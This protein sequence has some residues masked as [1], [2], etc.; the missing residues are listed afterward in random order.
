MGFSNISEEEI[1][2]MLE[3][4]ARDSSVV[5]KAKFVPLQEVDTEDAEHDIGFLGDINVELT[6]ELGETTKTVRE[7]LELEK[8]SV[9]PI[10]RLAGEHADIIINGVP[11]AS[12]E[13]VVINEVLGVRINTLIDPE[14]YNE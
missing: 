6:V 1:K 8:G 2:S 13:V 11:F 10:N 9:F 5:K 14:E 4:V 3:G 7:V 12:G